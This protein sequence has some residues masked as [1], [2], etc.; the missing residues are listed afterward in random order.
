MFLTLTREEA[1]GAQEITLLLYRL[2]THCA[3]FVA[4]TIDKLHQYLADMLRICFDVQGGI[5][6]IVFP[7]NA[8][9]TIV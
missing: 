5:F 1:F 6:C 4:E 3:K 7:I 9:L 8:G 2:C